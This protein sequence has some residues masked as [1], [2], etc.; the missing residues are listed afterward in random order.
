MSLVNLKNDHQH[1]KLD[2]QHLNIVT[3]T[4]KR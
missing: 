3:P 1:L 2:H 4:P